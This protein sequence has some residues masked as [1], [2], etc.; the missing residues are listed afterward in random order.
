MLVN[1]PGVTQAGTL[2]ASLALIAGNSAAQTGA[3]AARTKS[4]GTAAAAKR[5]VIWH[6]AGKRDAALEEQLHPL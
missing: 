1:R 2:L 6:P 5:T 4:A 3:A